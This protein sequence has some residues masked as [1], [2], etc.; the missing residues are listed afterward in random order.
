MNILDK[1]NKDQCK[2]ELPEFG[3][4]DRVK[5]HVKIVEGKTERIQIFTGDIIARKGCG[6]QETI[7]VRRVV[8]GQG[9]ERIFPINSP[10]LDKI[11]VER[12]GKVRRSKLYYLRDKVGKAAKIKEKKFA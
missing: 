5:V 1:I 4:G 3:V 2:A 11:V 7:T 10:R 12:R 6:I 8:S 9:V